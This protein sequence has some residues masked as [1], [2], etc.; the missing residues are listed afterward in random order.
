MTT[1]FKIFCL[2]HKTSDIPHWSNTLLDNPHLFQPH[3]E[4]K[5]DIVIFKILYFVENFTNWIAF[6]LCKSYCV[7]LQNKV[8]LREVSIFGVFL[9]RIFPHLDLDW[10]RRDISIRMRENM[11]QKNFEYGHFSHNVNE[12][13]K[14]F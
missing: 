7:S 4:K 9:V 10:I 5:I 2:L 1:V 8:T 12:T 14:P 11:D 3:R 6:Y 13:K